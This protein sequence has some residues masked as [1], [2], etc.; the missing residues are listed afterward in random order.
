[1]YAR[2]FD[3][4]YVGTEHVLLALLHEDAVTQETLATRGVTVE[5]VE[6][7]VAR[8]VGTATH[9]VPTFEEPLPLSPRLRHCVERADRLRESLRQGQVDPVHLLLALLADIHSAAGKA[10]VDLNIDVAELYDS[11]HDRLRAG[12]E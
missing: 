4:Q 6:D 3:Q 10:L 7:A 8:L 9:P 2:Q 11:L 1:M 12:V 5:Q